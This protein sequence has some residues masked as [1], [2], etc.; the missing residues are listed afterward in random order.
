MEQGV[1]LLSLSSTHRKI[2][3]EIV[4]KKLGWSFFN[5]DDH[6]TSL[7]LGSGG[8][9]ELNDFEKAEHSAVE[10]ALNQ[11]SVVVTVSYDVYS[12][13]DSM[14]NAFKKFY[15]YLPKNQL[16]ELDGDYVINKIA[17]SD[18]HNFLSKNFNVIDCSVLEKNKISDII[19]KKIR[20]KV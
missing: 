14:F 20:T 11:T 10:I 18:R 3:G 8:K 4:A 2:I 16:N 12:R 19:I 6:I 17:F 13:Y 9:L 15:L 5:I 1:I 7:L